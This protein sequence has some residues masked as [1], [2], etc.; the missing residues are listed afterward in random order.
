MKYNIMQILVL[1]FLMF[2]SGCE[3]LSGAGGGSNSSS[4]F[5]IGKMLNF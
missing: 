4:G 3:S 5:V 1:T 2:L